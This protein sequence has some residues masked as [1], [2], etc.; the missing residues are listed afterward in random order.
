[1]MKSKTHAT[2]YVMCKT[3]VNLERGGQGIKEIVDSTQV[4]GRE[5]LEV[6][7]RADLQNGVGG[8]RVPEVQTITLSEFMV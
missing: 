4:N 3:E 1:M 8:H 7:Y 5:I 2:Q 6:R